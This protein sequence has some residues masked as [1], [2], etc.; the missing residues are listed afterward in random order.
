MLGRDRTAA[1]AYFVK[2]DPAKGRPVQFRAWESTEWHLVCED[3]ETIEVEL[4]PELA[5]FVSER[6]KNLIYSTPWNSS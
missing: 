2:C 5:E 4:E 6:C 3:T 1:C